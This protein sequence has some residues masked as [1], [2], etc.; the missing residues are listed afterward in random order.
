MCYSRIIFGNKICNNENELKRNSS[1]IQY[2]DIN[3]IYPHMVIFSL[4]Y[5]A[6]LNSKLSG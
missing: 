4:E 2:L 6:I 1:H 3:K 5:K